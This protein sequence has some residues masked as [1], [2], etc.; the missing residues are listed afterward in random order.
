[1]GFLYTSGHIFR[2]PGGVTIGVAA[3]V[4]TY[5][6]IMVF[7]VYVNN[8]NHRIRLLVVSVASY[9]Y[10]ATV[11]ILRPQQFNILFLIQGEFKNQCGQA[12]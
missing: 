5:E 7:L 1:M 12:V 9:N 10:I 2:S 4:L 11:F 6:S 8:I 3:I